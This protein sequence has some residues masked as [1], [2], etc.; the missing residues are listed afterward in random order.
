MHPAPPSGTTPAPTGTRKATTNSGR[1]KT[2]ATSAT[3]IRFSQP[4]SSRRSSSYTPDRSPS[5]SSSELSSPQ[6]QRVANHGH[7]AERH[8]RARPNRA[9]Q[10][11]HKRVQHARR[12]RDADGVVDK[13]QK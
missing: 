3:S 11:A 12:H 5:S 13:R 9:D 4:L 7:G 2:E 6:P 1:S 10:Q 8:R